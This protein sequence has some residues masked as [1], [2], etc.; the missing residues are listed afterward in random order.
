MRPDGPSLVALARAQGLTVAWPF[1]AATPSY[2]PGL[3][4]RPKLTTVTVVMAS[5]VSIMWS[6]GGAAMLSRRRQTHIRFGLI[7]G[8]E[9]SDPA[10]IRPAHRRLRQRR[11]AVVNGFVSACP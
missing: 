6:T 7:L 10:A 5:L 11:P 3:Q 2:E 4:L 8:L 1:L 9:Q